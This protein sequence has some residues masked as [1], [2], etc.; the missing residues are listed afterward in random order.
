MKKSL[1]WFIFVLFSLWLTFACSSVI[2]KTEPRNVNKTGSIAGLVLCEG[3]PAA[4]AWVSVLGIKITIDSEGRFFISGLSPTDVYTVM[5]GGDRYI[6]SFATNVRVRPD[7]TTVIV[8]YL[9]YQP[10]PQRFGE[11]KGIMKSDSSSFLKMDYRQIWKLALPKAQEP[12]GKREVRIT[13][14]SMIEIPGPSYPGTFPG[15]PVELDR[16]Q[17]RPAPDKAAR[18]GNIAGIVYSGEPLPG[19]E[20]RV[21][22]LS[23]EWEE[24][25]EYKGIGGKIE[26]IWRKTGQKI[27]YTDSLGRYFFSGIELGK[28]EMS[29]WFWSKDGYIPFKVTKAQGI[30]V[31]PNSTS[32]VNF[33]I[34]PGLLLV[35]P[36]LIEHEEAIIVCDSSCFFG[37]RFEEILYVQPV[38]GD[39]RYKTGNIA[40]VGPPGVYVGLQYTGLKGAQTDSLGRYFIS[41]IKPGIYQI[42]ASGKDYESE[43]GSGIKIVADSTTVVFICFKERFRAPFVPDDIS[44]C[45]IGWKGVMIKCDKKCFFKKSR[46]EIVKLEKEYLNKKYPREGEK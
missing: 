32:I 22:R 40:G 14:D 24:A 26:R 16:E 20:V 44:P 35:E 13:G 10:P 37:K 4:D 38:T 45:R 46:E 42:A 3:S 12:S 23:G 30:K 25:I 31:A 27:T 18:T 8:L 15:G 39:P 29:A 9:N 33:G 2:K 7:S 19:A 34:V 5:A 21:R 41:G 6:K 1:I 43:I 11:V 17:M 28:Y 36:S